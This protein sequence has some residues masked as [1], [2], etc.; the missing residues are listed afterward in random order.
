LDAFGNLALPLPLNNNLLGNKGYVT[1]DMAGSK[2]VPNKTIGLLDTDTGNRSTTCARVK[3]CEHG[4]KYEIAALRI[5]NVHRSL[6]TEYVK[7][8][9]SLAN[10]WVCCKTHWLNQAKNRSNSDVQ[11]K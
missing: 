11:A 1:Q 2:T 8:F 4:Y 7:R 6:H 3:S 9:K 5:L 10:L